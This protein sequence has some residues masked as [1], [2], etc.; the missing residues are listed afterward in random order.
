MKWMVS[1]AQT[2][3][4]FLYLLKSTMLVVIQSVLGFKRQIPLNSIKPFLTHIHI[5]ILV[6][7]I[8]MFHLTILVLELG[9][10]LGFQL[11]DQIGQHST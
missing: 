5:N 2:L 7:L 4:V 3:K 1:I 9:T 10:E 6:L 8:I 11:Q